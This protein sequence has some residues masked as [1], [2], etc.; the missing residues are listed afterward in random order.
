MAKIFKC[1]M[2]KKRRN[3]TLILSEELPTKEKDPKRTGI[4]SY[5]FDHSP[6][7]VLEERRQMSRKHMFTQTDDGKYIIGMAIEN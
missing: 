2:C 7:P 4:R 6:F 1:D 3:I 5:C